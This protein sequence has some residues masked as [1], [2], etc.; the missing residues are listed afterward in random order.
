MPQGNL[1]PTAIPP[2]EIGEEHYFTPT[3]FFV[4]V[5]TTGS[6][7]IRTLTVTTPGWYSVDV[8]VQG[9]RIN[10]GHYFPNSSGAYLSFNPTINDWTPIQPIGRS[11][12]L[13]TSRSFLLLPN[14]FNIAESSIY[15]I[16]A[17]FHTEVPIY[18]G[19]ANYFPT[20][21]SGTNFTTRATFFR[22]R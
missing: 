16:R 12:N 6:F 7:A 22:Y 18:I 11:S 14:V 15:N 5:S 19:I 10:A 2:L 8:V 1:V 9:S 20:N 13:Y 21:S 3:T 4:D 17:W